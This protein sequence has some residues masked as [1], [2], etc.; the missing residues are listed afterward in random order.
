MNKVVT[1]ILYVGMFVTAATIAGVIT[2]T[3]SEKTHMD[4]EECVP[5]SDDNTVD[6]SV[7]EWYCNSGNAYD[8]SECPF[9]L[10]KTCNM[11][12]INGTLPCGHEKCLLELHFDTEMLIEKYKKQ[13]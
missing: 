2:Y 12:H 5:S 1:T 13:E 3:R 10:E 7:K 11:S 6:E 8:C 9:N 4:K